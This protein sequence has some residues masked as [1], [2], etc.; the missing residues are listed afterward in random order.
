LPGI[1]SSGIRG[2]HAIVRAGRGDTSPASANRL[3]RG[4]M[5]VEVALAIVLVTG[6]GLMTRTMFALSSIDPGFDPHNV[7]TMRFTLTGDRSTEA[8]RAAFDE[9]VVAFGDDVLTRARAVPGVEH[10]ALALSLPIEGSQWGSIF[11][12]GDQPVPERAAL[13]TA[14]FLPVSAGYFEAVRMQLRSGR[15]F[16]ATDTPSSQKTVV[17]NEAFARRFWPNESAVGKR[18]KQSWPEEP[19]PWRE[20]VGVVK[21]VKLDGIEAATPMQVYLPF[22]QN[23]VSTAALVVRTSTPPAALARPLASAIHQANPTLPIYGVQTMDELMRTA[24]TRRTM[25]MVI[26]AAFAVVALV[27][28]SVGLYGVVSQGVAERSREVGIRV[29]LGATRRQVIRLFVGQGVI[30]TTVGVAIGIAGALALARLVTDLLFNVAPT[31]A[32]TFLGAIATLMLVSTAA[33]YIPAR[34]AARVSPTITLRGD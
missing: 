11:I 14:A 4:L 32:M 18:V 2:Q 17:V 23:P 28:A 30:T 16:D 10:A 31:D 1:Q 9:R 7:I 21:D 22:T 33:C 13:P 12:V 5:I 26:F 24:V 8:L 29:A 20:I 6:A 34:R 3:R 15:F 19:T 25:T 27:M